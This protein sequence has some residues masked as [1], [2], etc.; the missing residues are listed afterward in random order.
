MPP[1]MRPVSS[2]WAVPF[3]GRTEKMVTSPVSFPDEGRMAVLADKTKWSDTGDTT[4]DT[5]R[6]RW[7]SATAT[8]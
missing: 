2:I 8:A 5:W 6:V 3:A 1:L 4:T 7:P